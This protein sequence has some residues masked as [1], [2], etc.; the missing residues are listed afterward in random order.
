MNIELISLIDTPDH[1]VPEDG[2]YI[3]KTISTGPLGIIHF[4]GTNVTRHQKNGNWYN[5]FGCSNQVV[6]AVSKFPVK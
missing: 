2:H 4:F 5:S 1:V 3:V 6:V